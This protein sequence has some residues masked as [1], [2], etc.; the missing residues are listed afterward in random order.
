MWEITTRIKTRISKRR[1][2]V[3]LTV[4]WTLAVAALIIATHRTFYLTSAKFRHYNIPY[5]IHSGPAFTDLA[6]VL[7]LAVGVLMG[8]FF[9]EVKRLIYSFFNTMVFSSLIGVVYVYVYIWSSLGLGQNLSQIAFG[10]ELA[11]FWAVVNVFRIMF[12]IGVI[13]SLI[14]FVVGSIVRIWISP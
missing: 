6:R 10:W 11:L 4:A 9:T 12:P 8:A 14:G 5:L 2:E 3:L 13:L 7:L 1:R